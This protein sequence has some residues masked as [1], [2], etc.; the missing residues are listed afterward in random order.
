MSKCS[1]LD[2]EELPAYDPEHQ[3]NGKF[4]VNRIHLV[5]YKSKNGTLINAD[6]NGSANIFRKSKQDLDFQ[7]LCV[8]LLASPGKK[9]A[10][11]C[12]SS[13]SHML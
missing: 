5:L 7:K 1:L 4:N 9:G 6:I 8:G 13:E 10:I 12:P 3:F 2:Q 11:D